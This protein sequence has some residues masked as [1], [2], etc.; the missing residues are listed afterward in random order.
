MILYEGSPVTMPA[1]LDT[2]VDRSA[3]VFSRSEGMQ[4]YQEA[5]DRFRASTPTH[6]YRPL[7]VARKRKLW[8]ANQGLEV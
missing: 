5:I 2:S 4:S 7:A 8:L 1:Y 6:S 3:G